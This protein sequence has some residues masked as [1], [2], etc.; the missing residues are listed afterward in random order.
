MASQTGYYDKLMSGNVA[1][2]GRAWPQQQLYNTYYPTRM[3][4]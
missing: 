3:P 1:G 4:F 2:E